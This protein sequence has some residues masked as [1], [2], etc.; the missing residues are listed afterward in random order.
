[1][2]RYEQWDIISGVGITALAVAAGRAIETQREDALVRDPYAESFVAAADS[3]VPMPTAPGDGDDRIWTEAAN[4]MGVRSRYF[5]DYF[6]EAAKEGIRQVVILAAGLDTRA[7]RL[8]WPVGT[9]VFEIDQPRVLDFKHGV[10]AENGAEPA[11]DR[12]AVAADLREEWPQALRDAGFDPARPTAWLAEGLLP[13]LPRHARN[14]LLDAVAGLSAPGSRIAIEHIVRP[15][16]MLD[17]PA[18]RDMSDRIGIDITSLMPEP[19]QPD[20][21]PPE[22]WFDSGSWQVSSEPVRSAANRYGRT[23]DLLTEHVPA[24]DFRFVTAYSGS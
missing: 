15:Q 7:Y 5:D 17:I 2:S 20:R 14:A 10:L 16:D 22:A 8:E 3:P 21:T 19:S 23:V 6:R 24:G 13:Y 12:Q 4:H 18:V 9:R 1:M 11:C